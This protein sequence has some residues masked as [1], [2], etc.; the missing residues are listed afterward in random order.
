M[1]TLKSRFISNLRTNGLGSW[2]DRVLLGVRGGKDSV[3]MAH[4]FKESDVLFS[5]AHVNHSLRG[6]ESD[7]DAVAV[8][9]LSKKLKVKFHQ[10]EAD[11]K[12]FCKKHKLTLQ[13]GARDLRYVWLEK[14][15]EEHGYTSIATAHHL[16]DSIETFFINLIRG[17]GIHGLTGIPVRNRRIIRPLTFATRVEIED[18]VSKNRLAYRED[19]SNLKDDYLRNRIRHQLIPLMEKLQPSFIEVMRGNLER[20]QLSRTLHDE[21]LSDLS[22]KLIQRKNKCKVINLEEINDRPNPEELLHSLLKL[23]GFDTHE[24][25]KLLVVG[26]PGKRFRDGD[27]EIIRDRHRLI[28]QDIAIDAEEPKTLK[29]APGHL[30]FIEGKLYVGRQRYRVGSEKKL[31]KGQLMLDAEH[32]IFPLEIRKWRSGD[33]FRPLGM[34]NHKKISD[35]LTDGK[36]SVSEKERT[37]VVLSAGEIICILGHRISENVKVTENTRNILL[38][39]W[40][41]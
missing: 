33:R 10:L 25:E 41:S 39:R 8:H 27:K 12:D 36:L 15:A 2:G 9:R 1:E 29:S 19:S 11:T 23:E 28:L 18:Y 34:R 22:K 37:L 40:L 3:A 4:L 21:R 14:I 30:K 5:I 7:D 20:L 38:F 6:K 31:A 16:N 24:P 17:T 13:E 32:V 26:K 35:F